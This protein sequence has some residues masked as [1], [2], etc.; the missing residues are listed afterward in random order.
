MDRRRLL[1]LTS[2]LPLTTL[3]ACITSR[4]HEDKAYFENLRGVLISADK[5]TL[6]VVGDQHHYIFDA[7]AALVAALDPALHPSIE[8]ASF[9]SF[10][11]DANNKISGNLALRTRRDATPAQRDL[12]AAAGFQV[13]EGQMLLELRMRG[14]RFAVRSGDPLPF[15]KLNRE[16]RVQVIEETGAAK[17]VLKAAATPVTVAA[18]GA[19]ILGAI[20][21]SPILLPLVLSK[22]CFICK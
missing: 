9:Q 14:E 7:P 16:Y 17:K 1:R 11:V 8:A 4:M 22:I 18:D 5:K 6:V 20:V 12:A 19:L 2:L 15:Q 21:L 3:S 13:K 10:S